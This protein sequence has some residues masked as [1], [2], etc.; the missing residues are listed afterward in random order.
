MQHGAQTRHS[1]NDLKSMSRYGSAKN[2]YQGRGKRFTDM[3]EL[4]VDIL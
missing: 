2:A 3:T 1:E 4:M